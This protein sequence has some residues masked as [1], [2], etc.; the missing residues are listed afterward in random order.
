MLLCKAETVDVK[1]LRKIVPSKTEI[2]YFFMDPEDQ[3]M[4]IGL[5]WYLK[6]TDRAVVTFSSLLHKYPNYRE[7]TRWLVQGYDPCR[8]HPI[9]TSKIHDVVFVG[10][11]T[12]SRKKL[13]DYLL[14]MGINIE[15]FG[16]GWDNQPIFD[17]ELNCLYNSS[18]LVLHFNRSRT[19]FSVR[20]VQAMA[21]NGMLISEAS[22][23]FEKV[24]LERE[25]F[26]TFRSHKQLVDLI[27]K[28]LSD[29]ELRQSSSS[30]QAKFVV[31]N[32]PW[33]K[34]LPKYLDQEK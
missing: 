5:S 10:T 19:D 23:D 32:L 27:F 6:W 33:S 12:K 24:F 20:V 7:K 8:F 34:V 15:C 25:I 18:K 11:K 14:T 29:G 3:A 26:P 30:S 1:S 13:V 4:R 28:Y 16:A 2:V 21:T 9:N 17:Y 22:K 31:E